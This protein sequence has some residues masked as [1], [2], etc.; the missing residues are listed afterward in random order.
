MIDRRTLLMALASSAS[1]ADAAP[2]WA[3]QRKVRLVGFLALPARPDPLESSRFGGFVRGMREVGTSRATI[4]R[5]S[6]AL[7]GEI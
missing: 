3:Q 5:S 4:S 6:G 2:V 1:F 7:L